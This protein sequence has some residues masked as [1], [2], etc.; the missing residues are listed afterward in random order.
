MDH[1]S[2]CLRCRTSG[3]RIDQCPLWQKQDDDEVAAAAVVSL[4]SNEES[5]LQEHSQNSNQLCTQ[6]STYN[7]TNYIATAEADDYVSR[8]KYILQ[9]VGG[10]EVAKRPSLPL[11]TLQSI[12]LRTTCPLCRLLFR[13]FPDVTSTSDQ[14]AVYC[15]RTLPSYERLRSPTKIADEGTKRRYAVY[16]AIETDEMMAATAL[17]ADPRLGLMWRQFRAFGLSSQNPL[18]GRD[19]MNARR[20]SPLV[21]FDLLRGW[22]HRC[23]SAHAHNCQ[24][25]WVDELETARMVD[26]H[27]RK[28]VPC[29]PHCRYVALSYVW[30]GVKAQ[31]GA[32]ETRRLPQTIEDAISVAK[33]L[34][35]RYLW[36]DMLCV[37]QTGSPQQAQQIAIMDRIYQGATL[38]VVALAD[39]HAD[40]GLPGLRSAYPR[41][42]QGLEVVND[43]EMLVLPPTAQHEQLSY[44]YKFR[45]WTMQ[46]E[47]LSRRRIAFT[48][49]EAHFVCNHANYYETIDE[50]VDPAEYFVLYDEDDMGTWLMNLDKVRETC[51]P[52]Q[53]MDVALGIYRNAVDE[54]TLRKMTNESD[55]LNAFVGLQNHLARNLF[56]NRT[57]VWGLPLQDC[58]QSLR[59]FH[60]R[61]CTP[62]RR[63]QFPSWSW[64]GWEGEVSYSGHMNLMSDENSELSDRVVDM[65]P[66][67][68]RIDD[69]V[70]TLEAH[71]VKIEVRTEPFSEAFVPGT[72]TLLG[73]MKERDFLHPTTVPSGVYDFLVVERFHYR[74]YYRVLP[75]NNR[76]RCEVY[77]ILLDLDPKDDMFTR[78]TKVRLWLEPDMD[79]MLAQPKV[80]QVKLK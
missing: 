20:V 2:L 21:D 30:G 41:H 68:V 5:S 43:A 73:R 49:H 75:G 74:P 18:P 80:A 9:L 71:L 50:S 3:H 22:V 32:L 65:R 7:I 59:W 28:I 23:E 77:L 16:F 69:Q 25:V 33:E 13:I 56:G 26:V 58:P 35:F 70:L 51:A 47:A 67:F 76:L 55:S 54:Y 4:R 38:T 39:G 66:T 53:R 57:F 62:K 27:A 44:Q 10:D 60:R 31:P 40:A 15:L 64:T 46:E 37:D 42:A 63:P 19:A 1:E 6:C 14:E 72:D 24:P 36:V 52:E 61:K 79:I 8:R 12:S 34:G 17:E 11:G 78:R 45:A 48:K 29:P